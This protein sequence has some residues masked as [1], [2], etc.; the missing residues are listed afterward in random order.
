MIVN[1]DDGPGSLREACR[2]KEPLWIVFEVSGTIHLSSYLSVS[3]YKT[4]DGR[5][6]KIKLTGKGI[7]LK[8][9]EHV[10]I[11]NLEVERG[12]GHDVDAIQI[13][14]NSKHIWIDRCTLS[15][16]ED[17]LIDITRGSTEITISR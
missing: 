4:V 7:K 11:C 15:D 13:K 16:C 8:Q 2:Q 6:Q 12:R 3:S 5:G 14:P 10:I 9:C 1:A 17:G